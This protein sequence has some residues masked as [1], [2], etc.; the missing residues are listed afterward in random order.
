MASRS[1][2]EYPHRPAKFL[3]EG[4]KS[5]T[6]CSPQAWMGLHLRKNIEAAMINPSQAV[7]R[8]CRGGDRHSKQNTGWVS[9]RRTPAA[10]YVCYYY[11]TEQPQTVPGAAEHC[12]SLPTTR[13]KQHAQIMLHGSAGEPTTLRGA[14]EGYTWSMQLKSTWLAKGWSRGAVSFLHSAHARPSVQLSSRRPARSSPS[15]FW[16]PTLSLVLRCP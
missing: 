13:R 7:A 3:W 14:T 12:A 2:R 9:L 10:R 11:V 5:S 6:P 15:Q 1:T 4:A 16:G 8:A